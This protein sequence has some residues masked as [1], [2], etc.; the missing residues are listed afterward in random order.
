[1]AKVGGPLSLVKVFTCFH[2]NLN[3]PRYPKS[4][5]LGSSSHWGQYPIPSDTIDTDGCHIAALRQAAVVDLIFS[6]SCDIILQQRLSAWAPDTF[7]WPFY[8]VHFHCIGSSSVFLDEDS[9]GNTEISKIL[10]ES[11]FEE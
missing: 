7:I 5:N 10:Q 8:G 11:M 2:T 3:I 9:G 1:M 6:W 4:T